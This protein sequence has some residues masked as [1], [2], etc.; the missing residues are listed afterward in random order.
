M[1]SLVGLVTGQITSMII[2][3]WVL[4][5]MLAVGPIWRRKHH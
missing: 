1:N 2:P 3:P 5:Q 4:F